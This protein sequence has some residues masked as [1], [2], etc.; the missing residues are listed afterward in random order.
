MMELATQVAFSS[1]SACTSAK[2]EPSH[3]IQALGMHADRAHS[4][5]R[6]GLGRFTTLSEVN[7]ATDRVIQ[8]VSRL[9]NIFV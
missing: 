9:K 5:V 1:G 8:T 2:I 7:V 6:F 4:S 3:V